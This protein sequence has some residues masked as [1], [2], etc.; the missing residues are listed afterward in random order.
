MAVLMGAIKKELTENQKK[1]LKKNV[2]IYDVEFIS[3]FF[4]RQGFKYISYRE[5]SIP[6]DGSPTVTIFNFIKNRIEKG[7]EDWLKAKYTNIYFSKYGF[8]TIKTSKGFLQY[9]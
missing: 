7:K 9:F 6:S 1:K 8:V 3:E 4:L 5:K 2:N